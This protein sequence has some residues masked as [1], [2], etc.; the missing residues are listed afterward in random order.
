M[1]TLFF[2]KKRF[3]EIPEDIVIPANINLVGQ[4]YQSIGNPINGGLSSTGSPTNYGQSVIAVVQKN[5]LN[6]TLTLAPSGITAGT[7]TSA[8]VTVGDDGRIIAISNGGSSGTNLSRIVRTSGNLSLEI[9]YYGDDAPTLS[10]SAGSYTITEPTGTL[11]TGIN[12]SGDNT[13]TDGDGDLQII[14]T[15]TDLYNHFMPIVLIDKS[16]N[17][18]QDLSLLASVQISETN[19]VNGTVVITLTSVSGF[20]ATGFRFLARS[21]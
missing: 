9:G 14:I 6:G 18:I 7:Y 3:I 4:G 17:Q 21:L 20:G 11:I 10:G 5:L 2:N 8:N 19:S 1:Q 16:N 13:I 12:G 15:S